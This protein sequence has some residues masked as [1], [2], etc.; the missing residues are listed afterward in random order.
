M[1]PQRREPDRATLG[2]GEA[3]VKSENNQV[4]SQLRYDNRMPPLART[5]VI[6]AM[7]AGLGAIGGL[8]GALA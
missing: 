7:L 5:V 3:K 8:Y 4:S 1:G 6:A 2:C